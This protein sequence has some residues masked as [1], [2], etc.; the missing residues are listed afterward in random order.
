MGGDFNAT[1]CELQTV[2]ELMRE[3]QWTDVGDR[4][5]WWGGKPDQLACHSRK[6]ANKSRID[7]IVVDCE[8]LGT[9]TRFEAEKNEFPHA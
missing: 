3:D 7:G 1:P 4:A 5:H 6:T 2:R 9:I 8:V